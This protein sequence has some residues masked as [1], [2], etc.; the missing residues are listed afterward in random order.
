VPAVEPPVRTRG[1]P[2]RDFHFSPVL[3]ISQE[4][5]GVE[6]AKVLERRRGVV[7]DWRA[8][9][10]VSEGVSVGSDDITLWAER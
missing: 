5:R 4:A 9:C 10:G 7:M 1:R 6:V 8:V 2:L 3:G